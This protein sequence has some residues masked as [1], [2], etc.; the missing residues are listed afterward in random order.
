VRN[1]SPPVIA[2]TRVGDAR[3]VQSP[4]VADVLPAAL[5]GPHHR[6]VRRLGSGAEA[7][8]ELRA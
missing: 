5:G 2:R 8:A 7:A 3:L 1:D 6:P 4:E